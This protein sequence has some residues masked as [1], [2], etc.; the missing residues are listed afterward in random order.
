MAKICM[1]AFSYYAVDSRTRREAEAL[2]SR[3]DEVDVVCLG[4]ESGEDFNYGC[5]KLFPITMKK[6]RGSSN[7]IY[8]FKYFGFF[9]LS[10]FK[11]TV[12]HFKKR[13]GVIQIHTLPD[14]LVFAAVIPKLF[15]AKIVLDVHELMPELYQSK[16]GVDDRHPLIRFITWMERRCIAFAD[17]ALAVHLPHKDILVKHGNPADKIGIVLNLPD[18]AIF[19]PNN[20]VNAPRSDNRFQMIYHGTIAKRH[21]LEV[22]LR[23]VALIKQHVSNFEFFVMGEGDD[24]ERVVS[25]AADLRLGD[26]VRFSEGSVPLQDIPARI[27][28]ADLGIVPMLYDAFTRYILPVKLMEYFW[29]GIPVVAPKTETM[30]A[31]F[32]E[33]MV[34]YFEPGNVTELA[35]HILDLYRNPHKR[36]EL[37][38]NANRFNQQFNWENQKAE[39]FRL[40]DSLTRRSS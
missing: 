15:G 6:Y 5:V 17:Y 35:S 10:A 12:L 28:Q 20:V 39:Y 36:K 4:E 32:D 37:V 30:L 33:T 38:L 18:P 7:L 34:R 14:F 11:L 26:G 29:L 19:V 21:G 24:R 1:L 3:G 2:C 9:V 8:L 22:A 40:V 16:F 31:Y 13:Y 25:L 23:A 27:K